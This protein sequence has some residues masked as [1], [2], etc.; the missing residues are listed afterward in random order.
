[1]FKNYKISNFTGRINAFRVIECLER[2]D[3][4]NV[5]ILKVFI[6]KNHLYEF[7]LMF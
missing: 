7:N 3:I 2:M 5:K 6:E 4:L 1:M